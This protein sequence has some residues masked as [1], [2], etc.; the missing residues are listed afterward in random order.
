MNEDSTANWDEGQWEAYGEAME[1]YAETQEAYAK[2]YAEK[3]EQ[4]FEKHEKEIEKWGEEFEIHAEKWA[5]EMEKNHEKHEEQMEKH[6]DQ[7][8]RNETIFESLFEQNEEQG[9]LSNPDATKDA[10][11]LLIEQLVADGY[12]KGNQGKTKM[13]FK[14]GNLTINNKTVSANVKAKYLDFF[15]NKYRLQILE[16]S[17]LTVKQ[18]SLRIETNEDSS[19]KKEDGERLFKF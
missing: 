10:H 12:R 18:K 9:F 4:H 3:I 8:D 19:I 2:E 13:R 11:Q 14:D 17:K 15:K 1:K 16:D 6:F 7:I 5:E